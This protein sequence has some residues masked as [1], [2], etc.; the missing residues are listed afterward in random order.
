MVFLE[1]SGSTALPEVSSEDS[2]VTFGH[3]LVPL[4]STSF[5]K[6]PV[7]MTPRFLIC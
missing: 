6:V 5:E 7:Q 4:E 3:C 1:A 2:L